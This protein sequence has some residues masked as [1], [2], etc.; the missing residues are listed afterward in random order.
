MWVRAFGNFVT[1]EI[2]RD[3][4]SDVSN[5]PESFRC[6][7]L[8]LLNELSRSTSAR[9]SSGGC[10]EFFIVDGNLFFGKLIKFGQASNLELVQLDAICVRSKVKADGDKLYEDLLRKVENESDEERDEN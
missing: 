10:F 3:F 6:A 8:G 2:S 7:P 4:A 1:S 5:L 9:R